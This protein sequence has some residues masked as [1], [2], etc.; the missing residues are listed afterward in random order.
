MT[1]PSRLPS[2]TQR[3]LSYISD[4][5]CNFDRLT[6]WFDDPNPIVRID[7]IKKHCSHV[8]IMPCTVASAY[9]RYWKSKLI[10]VNPTPYALKILG[11]DI[12]TRYQVKISYV[13]I[14]LDL[15][16]ETIKAAK[17]VQRYT[18]A[19]LSPDTQ[20]FRQEVEFEE[21]D[22]YWTAYYNHDPKHDIKIR[23]YIPV[24]GSKLAA[25]K[26]CNRTEF[27]FRGLPEVMKQGITNVQDL[28]RFDF[29]DFLE[30]HFVL[31]EFESLEDMGRLIAPADAGKSK[32][33]LYKHANRFIEE[34]SDFFFP[35]LI[36]N[37]LL[38][39]ADIPTTDLDVSH[40]L[41]ASYPGCEPPS[42]PAPIVPTFAAASSSVTSTKIF[43]PSQ[44]QLDIVK[45]VSTRYK[46]NQIVKLVVDAVAGAGKSSTV[47]LLVECLLA[48]GIDPQ[49]ILLISFT[50]SSID[51]LHGKL[52]EKIPT[53]NIRTFHSLGLS[54]IK[55]N[56]GSETDWAKMISRGHRALKRGLNI[57]YEFVIVDESQDMTLSMFE[58]F[59]EIIL[60]VPNF[61]M[62]GD[63]WQAIYDSF[64]GD[65]PKPDNLAEALGAYTLPLS[66]SYR[67]TQ[68]IADIAG[69]ICNREITGTGHGPTPRLVQF[70]A[71]DDPNV[72][73]ALEIQK[74]LA[75]GE[76]PSDIAVLT[77]EKAQQRPL[78][79]AL[80]AVGIRTKASYLEHKFH[81]RLE[82]QIPP[83]RK[84]NVRQPVTNDLCG[85]SVEFAFEILK[86]I[87]K[88]SDK[89][90]VRKDHMDIAH[91]ISAM[92]P[93]GLT[94]GLKKK[95]RQTFW[96]GVRTPSFQG[97]YLQ[98]TRILTC[99]KG[100][101]CDDNNDDNDELDNVKYQLNRFAA[102]AAGFS[103]AS[104]FKRFLNQWAEQEPVELITH[105]SAKGKEFK[106]VFVM[107]VVD[108]ALPH[109]RSR[110]VNEEKRLFYVAL[111]RSSQFLYLCQNP[112]FEVR[113]K[114]EGVVHD[115]PTPFLT[116]EVLGLTKK[117][118]P[119]RAELNKNIL[120]ILHS[121]KI[122]SAGEYKNSPA[123]GNRPRPARTT[124]FSK[125]ASKQN[126]PIPPSSVG[127]YQEDRY[128]DTPLPSRL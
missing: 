22:G 33:M 107:N 59:Q 120:R 35:F 18:V 73:I 88:Y 78:D 106:H 3:A 2:A 101:D 10:L 45:Y 48:L 20:R 27:A 96:H 64:S 82:K 21:S 29:K 103:C 90:L 42:I 25:G 55:Q 91:Y 28:I 112:M 94:E 81:C 13:E 9:Q 7:L 32:P 92:A 71:S 124:D 75:N 39:R 108:G 100:K 16:T 118:W 51:A 30:H 102:V 61:V 116:V 37:C 70:G 36:H 128:G 69:E 38:A 95:C 104:E 62:L 117:N 97:K 1:A 23:N 57:N 98:A 4:S 99:L 47:V 93:P 125:P 44:E 60:Q 122:D 15:I 126:C 56:T 14:A 8:K 43:E 24:E 119:R 87:E 6:I 72:V 115:R 66:T 54:F 65:K 40:F 79:R 68:Q 26:P 11:E 49:Q 80:M 31:S 83:Y 63:S 121:Y 110:D 127:D 12:G 5:L 123:C 105:H 74:L 113:V 52:K 111:S 76:S 84:R 34:R 114:K 53:L 67:M 58:F 77:R 50:N 89:Q 109:Y 19:R 85:E 86:E 41:P 46:R 17:H